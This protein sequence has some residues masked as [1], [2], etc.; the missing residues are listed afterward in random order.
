MLNLCYNGARF[1]GRKTKG[2]RPKGLQLQSFK[3]TQANKMGN[4]SSSLIFK[5]FGNF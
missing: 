1:D 4:P 2:Q 3:Y 5:Y